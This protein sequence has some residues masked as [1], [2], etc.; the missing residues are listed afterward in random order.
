MIVFLRGRF[1]DDATASVSIHDLGFLHGDA[2]FETARLHRGG[3]F[4]LEHHLDRLAASAAMLRIAVPPHDL[5]ASIADQLAVRN[6]LEEATLRITVT[7]GPPEGEPTVLAT[8]Q[9]ISSEWVRRAERGWRV[10]TAH[11]RRPG[12]DSMPAQL[13]SVGRTYSLL[14]RLEAAPVRADDVLLLS[15]AGHVCEGPTWNV[16]W[17][18]GSVLRTPSPETG[19]LEGITRAVIMDIAPLNGF[20]IEQGEWGRS[21]L[22]NVEEIFATMSSVG[23]VPIRT[24]DGHPLPSDAAAHLL[25]AR[26]WDLVAREVTHHAEA[27]A[28]RGERIVHTRRSS[29][30]Q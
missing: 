9:P 1:T 20:S 17:R 6:A 29:G 16:F 26:Y 18:R 10:I 25:Q 5:L 13:K 15:E 30:Q 2:V 11:I 22:D 14:A 4:R 12:T 3:F 28:A 23:V 24:L 27:R 21:D 8:L 7:R 19:V